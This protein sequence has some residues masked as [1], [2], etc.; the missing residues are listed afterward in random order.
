MNQ[1][2][3]NKA[4]VLNKENNH[5]YICKQMLKNGY[6]HFFTSSEIAFSKKFKKNI[7]NNSAFTD[8]LNLIAVNK[9]HLVD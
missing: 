2:P 5:K 8:K 4:L 1:I 9:I 6:T 7:L 3:N